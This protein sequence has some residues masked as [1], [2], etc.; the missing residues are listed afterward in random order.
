MG[1]DQR[2]A[3]PFRSSGGPASCG[4]HEYIESVRI[5]ILLRLPGHYIR[6]EHDGHQYTTK[7]ALKVVIWLRKFDDK[8]SVRWQSFRFLVRLILT[9]L[10]SLFS[11]YTDMTVVKKSLE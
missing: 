8:M 1:R 11:K 10:C 9:L 4:Q 3:G 5:D 2:A 7:L 6:G